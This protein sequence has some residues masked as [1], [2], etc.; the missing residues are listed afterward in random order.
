MEGSER[1][2][3]ILIRTPRSE[4]P[5]M[6]ADSSRLSGR[7]VKKVFRMIMLNTLMAP[8]RIRLH[9]VFIISRFLISI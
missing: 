3:T 9:T 8:G 4:H 1:G 2:S 6:E 7:L 5:S